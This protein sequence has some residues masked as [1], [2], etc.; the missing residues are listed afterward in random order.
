MRR[1]R[2]TV[3]TR[4]EWQ[5]KIRACGGSQWRMGPTFFKCF[6]FYLLIYLLAVQVIYEHLQLAEHQPISDELRRF[7]TTCAQL[8]WSLTAQRPAYVLEYQLR[9]AVFDEDR[10]RRFH[11]SDPSSSVIAQVVWPGLVEQSTRFCVSKAVV[12][13]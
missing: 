1:R 6:L 9:G 2:A 4:G 13:T 7:V 8:A 11:T 5:C 12:V 3:A 10:H